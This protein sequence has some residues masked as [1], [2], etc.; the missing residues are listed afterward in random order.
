M[1]LENIRIVLVES[2]H[3]G[4]IGA[5]ARAM[6]T[7]GLTRLFLVRPKT[8][9]PSYEA[10]RRAA[11]S[12]DV[13]AAA[14]V[15]D[16]LDSVTGDCRLVVGGTARARTHRHPVLDARECGRKLFAEA[17]GD[18]PLA[19][20]FGPERTG[21]SNDDL[22]RCNFELRIPTSAAF[23]SLN[24]A[25]AV[26]LLCYEVHMASIEADRGAASP[27]VASDYP[28]QREMEFFFGHLEQT[29]DARE[30]TADARTEITRSKLRR[31][32]GRAR[33]RA[34]ELK[35]LHS[36]VRLMDRDPNGD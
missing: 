32:F 20:L 28:T 11:G 4:N 27:A 30:F 6:K 24:L 15:T 16:D 22:D 21:L 8:P 18:D 12:Q 2:Q 34:G 14:V 1:S 19:V 31:L 7:M 5:T 3:P 26:Q 23:S 29:L 9:C 33:P 25:A 13:L 36:L 35:M 10:E 17:T